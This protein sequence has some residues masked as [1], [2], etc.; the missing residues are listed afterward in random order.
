MAMTHEERMALAIEFNKRFVASNYTNKKVA[1]D[2]IT[3]STLTQTEIDELLYIY[4]PWVPGKVLTA[5]TYVRYNGLL[6]K[7]VQGHTTQAD[8][9]PDLVPALFTVVAPV[10]VTPAWKQ[11][12]GSQ[13]AYNIGDEVMFEGKKYKSLINANT[14]SPTVYPAGWQLIS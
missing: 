6:Y 13:D 11:P 9:T 4:D 8:W 5:G 2:I 14:W 1:E 10:G 3:A 12:T 7:V